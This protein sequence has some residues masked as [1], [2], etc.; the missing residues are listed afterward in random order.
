[1]LC[2]RTHL[3]VSDGGII[4]HLLV[5]VAKHSLPQQVNEHCTRN[6]SSKASAVA[7]LLNHRERVV[8]VRAQHLHQVSGGLHRRETHHLYAKKARVK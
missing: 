5:Q 8:P 3:E 6:N 7:L 1:M 2:A 4:A